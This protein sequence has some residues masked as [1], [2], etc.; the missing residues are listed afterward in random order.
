[1]PKKHIGYINLY[2]DHWGDYL[3]WAGSIYP[4]AKEALHNKLKRQK[5]CLL[6]EVFIEEDTCH[7]I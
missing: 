6:G 2:P 4:T 7:E 5:H 1:V 3:H